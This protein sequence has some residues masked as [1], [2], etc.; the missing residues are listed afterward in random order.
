MV[1]MTMTGTGGAVTTSA[2]IKI[3][4]VVIVVMSI[5]IS[6]ATSGNWSAIV[7]DSVNMNASTTIARHNAS[8]KG[9]AIDMATPGTTH[10]RPKETVMNAPWTGSNLPVQPG[11]KKHSAN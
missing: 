4:A 3:V 7:G 5:A 9:C 6:D 1:A 8:A 11:V 2:T 10:R